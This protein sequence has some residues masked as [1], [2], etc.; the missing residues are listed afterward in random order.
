[1]QKLKNI[2]K[3]HL[4][5]NV[6]DIFIIGSYLKNKIN[7]NDLDMIILFKEKEM[8]I[9]QENLF[10]IKEDTDFIKNMHIEPLFVYS[11]LEESIF[12]TILH[13]GFSIKENKFVSD[14]LKIK[15]YCIFS[16]NLENLSKI[17]KVRFAQALY[18]RKKDGILYKEKAVSLGQGSFMTLVEKEEIFKEFFKE[19]KVKFAR[20][21]A[22]VND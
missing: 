8:K 1:M 7:P 10:Q 19:W 4:K 5:N 20:K 9:V 21:K 11:V 22:F 13:E 3:K 16:Y 12:L 17:D 18:G 15:P 14:L 6:A 2:L